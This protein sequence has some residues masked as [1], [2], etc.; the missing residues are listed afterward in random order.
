MNLIQLIAL[1][2]HSCPTEDVSPHHIHEEI[3]SERFKTEAWVTE[4]LA[5][6]KLKPH[7]ARSMAGRP[8]S[9]PPPPPPHPHFPAL[10]PRLSWPSAAAPSPIH[11]GPFILLSWL[12]PDQWLRNSSLILSLLGAGVGIGWG[13]AG[14]GGSLMASLCY[15]LWPSLHFLPPP[16]HTQLSILHL[17]RASGPPP[18]PQP[19]SLLPSEVSLT[20]LLGSD[21][22]SQ[23]HPVMALVPAA[24]N[25]D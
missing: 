3:F 12:Q 17:P 20:W 4:L 11:S 19:Q 21:L 8:Y 1:N 10:G 22:L 9:T 5:Q 25:T 23:A 15:Q 7:A 6:S 13:G 24:I 2:P 18:P 14:E 16:S